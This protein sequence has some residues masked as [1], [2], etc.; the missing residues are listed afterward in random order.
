MCTNGLCTVLGRLDVGRIIAVQSEPGEMRRDQDQQYVYVE[1]SD[2]RFWFSREYVTW[3][4][5]TANDSTEKRMPRFMIERD[6]EDG[7]E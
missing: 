2:G 5:K 4:G 1:F 6:L 7:R 3:V